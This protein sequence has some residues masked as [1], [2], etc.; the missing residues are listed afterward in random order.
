MATRVG[1]PTVAAAVG[2][3]PESVTVGVVVKFTPGFVTVML[4]TTPPVTFAI[5]VANCPS[6]PVTSTIGAPW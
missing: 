5:A 6:P 4:V 2:L 1:V 3:P